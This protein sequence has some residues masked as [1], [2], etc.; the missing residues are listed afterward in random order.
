VWTALPPRSN[1]VEGRMPTADEAVAY[2]QAL[3]G[4]VLDHARD[5]VRRVHR[6]IATG[7]RTMIERRLGWTPIDPND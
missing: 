1:G 7:H 5:Y 2:L 4:D 6:S 3:E